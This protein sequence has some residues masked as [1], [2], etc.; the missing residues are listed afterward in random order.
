MKITQTLFL[1]LAA[2]ALQCPAF[3]QQ[4]VISDKSEIRFAGKQMNV[5]MDGTFKKFVA[6]VSFD[7]KKLD[8]SRAQLSIEIQSIDLGSAEA[9]TEIKRKPWFDAA[10]YPQAKFVSTGVKSLGGNRYEMAGKVTIKATTKDIVVPFTV[11]PESGGNSVL[12]G[13]L[14]LKRLD[15]KVG[16]GPWADTETVANEVSIKFRLVVAGIPR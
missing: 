13:A 9:E 4:K 11:K 1:S 16:D 7:P 6:E 5:D 2:L 8:T 15:F 3:A 12:E 14:E 10:T